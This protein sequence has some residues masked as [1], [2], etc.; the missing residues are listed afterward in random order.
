MTR[1]FGLTMFYFGRKRERE[2][3]GHTNSQS[4]RYIRSR[5]DACPSESPIYLSSCKIF[6]R[7]FHNI[8]KI[9]FYRRHLADNSTEENRANVKFLLENKNIKY[10]YISIRNKFAKIR[11]RSCKNPNKISFVL[12]IKNNIRLSVAQ[13]LVSRNGDD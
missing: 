13:S 4:S 12:F 8:K 2:R 11:D 7:V 6:I 3:E 10:I 9:D 1:F 5:I